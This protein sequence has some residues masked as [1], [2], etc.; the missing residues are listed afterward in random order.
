MKYDITLERI[1]N[2]YYNLGLERAR[3]RDLSGAAELLKKALHFDKY[4][5]EA[6]NLLGLIFFEMGEV[7]DAL[8]QWV[9]SMNLLPEDNPADYFLEQIQRKPAILRICSDNVKR[10]NQALDY[11]Q[12][13]NED[14]AVFQL[15]QVIGDSP[16]YVKAHILLSLL[17]MRRSE[18]VKAGKSLY[19][20]LKIDRNNPKALVLMDYVKKK[21]GRAEVEQSRLRNVFSHRKMM[22]DDVMMPQEVKQISP[23]AV[24]ALLLLGVVI[25]LFVFYLLMLPAGIRRANSKNNQ[26]MISYT[27]KLDAANQKMGD[28]SAANASL[29]KEY[30]EMKEK[31]DRYENQNASFMAQYQS[32]V[33]INNA[34]STGDLTQAA[35]LYTALDQSAITDESL[36]SMLSSIKSQMEG[37]VYLRLQEL[38]STAW[39]AGRLEEALQD[40]TWSV[41]IRRE[42]ENL[43]LLARIQQTMGNTTEANQNFDSVVG[44]FPSSPYAERARQARG[45]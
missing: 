29:Q 20:V 35:Q 17:Y 16:N 18:W 27:E 1:A 4:E 38:G 43:F 12:H 37:S 22:D 33:G 31:L 34:L 26:E 19:L 44:E 9:I 24:S 40:Y 42:A 21:T 8:V 7:A 32:L 41:K 10:Y 23:W 28:L 3:L 6:R 25:A 5:R 36:V 30:D 2:C 11:A 39:N 15:N 14:L 13:N 45:Y